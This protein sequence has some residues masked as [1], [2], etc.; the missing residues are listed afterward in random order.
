MSKE[1]SDWLE[2][3]RTLA[4]ALDNLARAID[5]FARVQV[6]DRE[7]RTK[8]A[9]ETAEANEELM[10]NAFAPLMQIMNAGL[11]KVGLPRTASVVPL[12]GGKAPLVCAHPG[13]TAQHPSLTQAEVP[14]DAGWL[15]P[16]HERG[17]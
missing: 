14:S 5:D 6:E 17:D 4:R 2:A 1:S 12:R 11:P 8:H 9:R 13:C 16:E 7:H 3:S 15:C 10:R